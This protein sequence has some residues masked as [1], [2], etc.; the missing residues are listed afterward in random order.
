MKE[1]KILIIT[2]N[3]PENSS[4]RQNAGIFVYDFATQLKKTN[5][6]CY[7]VSLGKTDRKLIVSGIPV[8]WFKF[9]GEKSL[10]KLQ[11]WN[12]MD[13][14][15]LIVI[16]WRGFEATQK[17]IKEVKPDYCLAMWAMPGGIFAYYA[18][19]RFGVPY[20]VWALG[21]DI[22]IYGKRPFI[23][24]VIKKVLKSA[25][26]LFAD[27]IDLSQQVKLISAKKCVF[28]PSTTNFDDNIKSKLLKSNTKKQVTLTFVGRLE[29]VKG[30]DILIDALILLE[31]ELNNF[32]VNIIGDGS[33]YQVLREKAKK[34][35]FDKHVTFYGNVSNKKKIM[36]ILKNSHWMIIPSRSDS[37]PLVFS[38][39]MKA[40]VPIIASAL[41]D[42]KHVIT[43]YRVG[44]LF[45]PG[46]ITELAKLLRKLPKAEKE[47]KHFV[48]NTIKAAEDF[49]LETSSRKF[50][51]TINR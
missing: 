23:K 30:P 34:E 50:I 43:S 35:K 33:L 13:L 11:L 24:S 37:I 42:L 9:S 14:Y 40:G 1:N 22:Y 27:G 31:N 39:G 5:I 6:D 38:E 4:D 46:K 10:L 20:A 17:A 36:S 16:F 3:Y 48:Q 51:S 49:S 44:H 47:R 19:L 12:P 15:N 8:F 41:P 18:K 29:P 21:S 32:K 7:V 25:N 45:K 2:H 26:Y 28:L